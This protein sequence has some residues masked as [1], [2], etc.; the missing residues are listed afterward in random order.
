V[1]YLKKNKREFAIVFHSFDQNLPN[2]VKEFNLFCQGNH[3]CFNGKNGLPSAKF[4]NSKG[5]RYM[6][7]NTSNCAYMLRRTD[8]PDDNHLVVGTL[9][10]VALADQ[11]P[12]T[13]PNLNELLLRDVEQKKVTVHSGFN[14][15]FL[16]LHQNLKDVDCC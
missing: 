12:K 4:D 15:I 11:I 3:P 10:R 8:N 16:K 5:N 6:E 14:E 7:L 9:E 2:V 13:N 1:L